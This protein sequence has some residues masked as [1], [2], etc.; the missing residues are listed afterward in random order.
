MKRIL[1]SE[2]YRE[3]PCSVVAVGCALKI[4]EKSK[5]DAL[6][7]SRLHSDGYLSLKG[8]DE[9][10]R[11]FLGVTKRTTYKRGQRPCLR[12]FCHGYNGKAVVCLL[13]HFVYIEGGDY[14]SFFFNG[15][16]DVVA[17]WKIE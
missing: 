4:A 12:D 2:I 7:S 17:V 13:G 15:G 8:M 10:M 1:P 3:L 14:Y 16:D 9:L 6:F 11:A 5:L